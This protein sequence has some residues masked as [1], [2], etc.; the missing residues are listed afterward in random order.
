MNFNSLLNQFLGTNDN[1]TQGIAGGA[2]GVGDS[3]GKIT[4]HIPGGLAGGAAAGG[5]VA[6]LMGSKKARKFAGK[7]VSYGGA[8]VLGG[9]AFKAYQNWKANADADASAQTSSPATSD[10]HAFHQQALADH[11]ADQTPFEIT[12]IKAMI[13]A[14]KA[15]GHI[16]AQEQARIF[17]AVERMN[18]SAQDKGLI[19]DYLRQDISI[20]ELAA[21]ARGMESRSELYLASCL[22]MQID[23]P[24][25]RDYLNRLSVALQLPAELAA[26]LENQAQQALA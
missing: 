26:Q 8:A 25:E 13:A 22:V 2:G 14:A 7:A 23:H 11:G 16:D 19:F 12:L 21:N 1:A 17:E 20:D 4:S 9:L 18:L 5:I 3:L 10:D 6:L 15:D 24:A